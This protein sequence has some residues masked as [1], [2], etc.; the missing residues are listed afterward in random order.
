MKHRTEQQMMDLILGIAERDERV[1]AVWI[2][3][4]RANPNAPRDQYQDFDIVYAVTDMQSMIG[5]P[6]WIDIFGERVIMQTRADQLDSD[7]P[8]EDWF[9]FMMQLLD[10]NRIDLTLVPLELAAEVAQSDSLC[11]VLLDKDG[12]L[13]ELPPPSDENYWVKKPTER[14]YLCTCNE[15]LWVSTYVAKGIWRREM[16][17]A[18]G[19]LSECVRPMLIKMVEWKIGLD[20]HFRVD[21]GKLGKYIERH[22]YSDQWQ[23]FAASFAGGNYEDMMKGLLSM[24]ELFRSCGREVGEALGFDYPEEDDLRVSAYI[25]CG[26]RFEKIEELLNRARGPRREEEPAPQDHQTV[27]VQQEEPPQFRYR[28][29]REGVK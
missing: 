16:A 19:M 9:N 11:R 2:N 7:P 15:F 4:S 21:T 1:R 27:V 24:G 26:G 25:R 20:N 17:Y 8:Y 10:G 6:G 12:I 28:R 29:M 14:E 5:E 13:P 18:N 3:G 22:L 23:L